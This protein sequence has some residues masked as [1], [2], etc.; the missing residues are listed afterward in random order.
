MTTTPHS[1]REW[2]INALA[3]AVEYGKCFR[4]LP[5]TLIGMEGLIAAT[6]TRPFKS[7]SL[8]SQRGIRVE[9]NGVHSLDGKLVD[10][11][12]MCAV[13]V[14]GKEWAAERLCQRK[15]PRMVTFKTRYDGQYIRLDAPGCP[16]LKLSPHELHPRHEGVPVLMS[17]KTGEIVYG[18][19][20]TARHPLTLWVQ[21]AFRQM[22]NPDP[23]FEPRKVLVLFPSLDHRRPVTLMHSGGEDV[24]TVFS[25]GGHGH[26]VSATTHKWLNHGLEHRYGRGF[27]GIEIEAWGMNIVLDGIPPNAEDLMKA[28]EIDGPDG[29][30][31]VDFETFCVRCPM[32]GVEQG[33][34]RRKDAEPLKSLCVERPH[35]EDAPSDG[36]FGWNVRFPKESWGKRILVNARFRVI[37][38]R[39]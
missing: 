15:E 14:E 3:S 24:T 36:T 22:K 25:D 27:R 31:R 11:G 7:F 17:S 38:E 23:S 5:A 28:I 9:Q 35:R 21:E 2:L 13:E 1:F 6:Y 29:P 30:V 26:A 16:T 12:V 39:V 4:K 37:A 18:A 10:R 34:G 19:P 20:A 8:V 32:T 33:T